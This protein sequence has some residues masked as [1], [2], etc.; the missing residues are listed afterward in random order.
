M[1]GTAKAGLLGGGTMPN[2][3][4]GVDPSQAQVI[5][6]NVQAGQNLYSDL[7]LSNSSMAVQDAQGTA[8]RQFAGF[9]QQ[10]I[11]DQLAAAGLQ[12]QL[13]AQQF[14]QAGTLGNTLGQLGTG[15]AGIFGA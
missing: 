9:E 2:I 4:G 5:G 8:A 6:Q 15:I 13:N 12:A 1:M 10:N 11:N 7:G 3:T 14:A